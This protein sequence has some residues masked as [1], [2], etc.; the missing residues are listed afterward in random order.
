MKTLK[1]KI[2]KPIDATWDEFGTVLRDLRY[3]SSKILNY[4]IQQNYEWHNFRL[5]YKK[6]HGVYPKSSEIF[7]IAID[8]KMYQKCR[9]LYPHIYA[10][11]MTQTIKSATLRWNN[12]A[13]D[14]MLLKKSIPSYKI[15]CSIFIRNDTFKIIEEENG[16]KID[17]GL[18]SKSS[19][20]QTRYTIAIAVEDNSTKTILNRIMSGEYKK[21]FGQI[22]YNK[23]G[24]GKWFFNISFGFENEITENKGSVMGIDLGIAYPL[25][26]A[27][28]DNLARYKIKGGE[29]E[30]FRRQIQRRKNDLL[31][32]G[33]YCGD[34]RKGHGIKTRISPID[35]ATKRI[36]NFRDTANHKYSEFAIRMAIKHACGLIVME[37]LEGINENNKF[38]KRWSYYDLQQKIEYKAK[39]K[40]I[41]VLYINPYKT[42]QRCSKC[43]YIDRENREDQSTFICKNCE[44]EVNADF[45]AARN[46]ATPGIEA[47][48]KQQCADFDN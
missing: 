30:Q 44:F 34:G 33:R 2:I 21:G 37:K 35:F 26:I 42:S 19:G 3:M 45:N 9:E 8:T 39:E 17:V 43:G 11:N 5:E 28:N 24:S 41:E 38:L 10:G 36:A 1:L 48:I 12:D 6:E 32:Q 4:T 47:L 25:Y 29:I 23:R 20:K 40:G 15:N 27:F 46:I 7:G 31:D 14:I 22:T 16:Y 13:R 18:L